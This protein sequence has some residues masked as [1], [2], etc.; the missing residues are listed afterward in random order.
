MLQFI[1]GEQGDSANR[2]GWW[3][4]LKD[5]FLKSHRVEYQDHLL[6]LNNTIL[7]PDVVSD[8]VDRV[9]E[10]SDPEEAA[11]SASGVDCSFAGRITSFKNFAQQR[12][13]IVNKQISG[14]DLDAGSD[15]VVFA[16]E[17]VQFDARASVPDPGPQIEYTWEN[18][19]V[20]DYPTFRY[21][22]AGTYT[23][24]LSVTAR[25][26]TFTDSVQVEVIPIPERVYLEKSGQLVMEVETFFQNVRRDNEKTWWEEASSQAGFSGKGYMEAIEE[27]RKTFSSSRHVGVAPELRYAIRF[28]NPGP[29]R[30]WVR[31]FA[32]ESRKDSIYLAFDSLARTSGFYHRWRDLDETN[33]IWSGDTNRVGPQILEVVEPGLKLFSIWIKESGVVIDKV[34]MTTNLEYV[35]EGVGLEPSPLGSPGG[36][37]SFVR[38]DVNDSGRL[39]VSDAILI[40]RHLFLGGSLECEDVADADDSGALDTTD[41][42]LVIRYIFLRG[43]PP[44]APFPTAGFD[45][46]A[47]GFD[48]GDP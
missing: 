32:P 15:Q 19:M 38:G 36:A 13:V 34:L 44:E 25:G 5:A 22:E 4:Y 8:L 30:V 40:W 14:V 48:C 3:H 42:I 11:R 12:F 41:P 9:T 33:F 24:T 2:S 46:T 21:D 29:Y 45:E 37:E 27:D 43:R 26:V 18:G 6:L 16:G 47:D 7:H 1:V 10:E 17:T 20:G 31:A 35:P 39:D 28:T 23:V